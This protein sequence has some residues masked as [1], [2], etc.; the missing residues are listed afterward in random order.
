MYSHPERLTALIGELSKLPGI[1]PRSAERL[2]LFIVQGGATAATQLAQAI[3]QAREKIQ[4][5]RVCGAL[6]ETQPCA[7]CSDPR[8]DPE[9]VC[10]VERPVDILSIEK[11]GIYKGLYHVLGG[12]ISPINGIG[13]EDLN[14]SGLEKRIAEGR[15]REIILALGSDVEGDATSYFLA[16]RMAA[17][18]VKFS[19]LAHGLP[20]GTS[21]EFADELTLS[22]AI[23]G[24]RI[25][26]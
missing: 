6:T 9:T 5:C 15:I 2:A 3:I 23:E 16:Q 20:V 14:I 8:R 13:P 10:L 11:S 21:L 22:R 7:I 12:R 18:A 19:R 1:G 17:H 4:A 26:E 24:R 25:L